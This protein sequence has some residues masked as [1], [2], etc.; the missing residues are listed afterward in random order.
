[1]H[2]ELL[3]TLARIYCDTER[4]FKYRG[5]GLECNYPFPSWDSLGW[6]GLDHARLKYLVRNGYLCDTCGR[7]GTGWRLKVTARG[8]DALWNESLHLPSPD[9]CE[10]CAEERLCGYEGK[11]VDCIDT[12]WGYIQCGYIW[13]GRDGLPRAEA[14]EW[15]PEG[16]KV[17]S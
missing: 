13:K 14:V 5:T 17:A 3:K 2:S 12:A 1:M 4:A 6:V 16:W 7:D 10:S 11:C 8:R 15:E 9:F